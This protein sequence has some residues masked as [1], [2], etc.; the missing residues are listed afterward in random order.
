MQAAS[1]YATFVYCFLPLALI[2]GFYGRTARKLLQ[3]EVHM[4]DHTEQRRKRNKAARFV[5]F[6]EN[7]QQIFLSSCQGNGSTCGIG[8][9]TQRG[10]ACCLVVSLELL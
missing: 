9:L 10:G 6:S 2:A 1:L 7:T 3:Q 5:V 4:A 8:R